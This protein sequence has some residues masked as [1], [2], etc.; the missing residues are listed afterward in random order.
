MAGC[1]SKNA[2]SDASSV[3][4]TEKAI[5]GSSLESTDTEEADSSALMTIKTGEG[6]LYYPKKYEDSL[7]TKESD[8]DGILTVEFTA[9]IDEKSYHLFKVMICDEEGD[10]VGTITDNEGGT[11]NVFVDVN[12]LKDISNL[13][14]NV[15]DLLYSMQE[16][17]NVLI[18]N[19]K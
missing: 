16:G 2:P 15:Q 13:D 18:E 9:E 1:G 12:E 7:Q 8:E 6:N 17:V 5:D 10:S 19:L 3:S 4:P 14:D 11:H